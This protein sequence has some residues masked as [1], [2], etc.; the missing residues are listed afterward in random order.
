AHTEIDAIPLHDALPIYIDELDVA[1]RSGVDRRGADRQSRQVKPGIG[2]QI[3][4]LLPLGQ[5]RAG[6]RLDPI[7]GGADPAEGNQVVDPAQDR[8]STRLNSSHVKISY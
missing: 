2:T 8:K 4:L 7:Y 6:G 1:D 3:G 5:C